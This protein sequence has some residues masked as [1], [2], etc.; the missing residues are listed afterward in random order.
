M[1]LPNPDLPTFSPERKIRVRTALISVSEK[2]NLIKHAKALSERGISLISTGGTYRTIS[3]SGIPVRDVSNL[4]QYPE[5]MDGR[6]K[7]LHP[8]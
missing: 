1:S 6:V 4:T 5:I 8:G 2:S 7:T 3:K